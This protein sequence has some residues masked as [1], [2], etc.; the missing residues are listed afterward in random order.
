MNNKK[1]TLAI[2]FNELGTLII[3]C[4]ICVGLWL[5][6]WQFIKSDDI[7]I[8]LAVFAVAALAC[9]I[10]IDISISARMS[11]KLG[12]LSVKPV[13]AN[14]F[15]L[16]N[17][18]EIEK[19]FSAAE[20][21][22]YNSIKQVTTRAIIVL[23]ALFATSFLLGAAEIPF[24]DNEG[25]IT[26]SVL[27]M[28]CL[29]TQ[30][31]ISYLFKIIVSEAPD[32]KTELTQN[33]YPL[34]NS[35]IKES[36]EKMKITKPV[37]VF[38]TSSGIGVSEWS[39]VVYIYLN[40]I[41]TALLTKDELRSVI[42][43]EF[44]HYL[45]KDTKK[46]LLYAQFSQKI[47]GAVSAFGIKAILSSSISKAIFNLTMYEAVS[48][49]EKEIKADEYVIECGEAQNYINA[50]AKAA[51]F[52][53]YNGYEWKETSYDV[54][55]SETPV[56][57]IAH[58]DL[59]NYFKQLEIYRER[60]YFTLDNELPQRIDSHPTFA[61]RKK[62]CNVESYNAERYETDP[63]Y[64][65]EQERLLSLTDKLA[66]DNFNIEEYKAARKSIYDERNEILRQMNEAGESFAFASENEKMRCAQALMII[67]KQRALELFNEVLATSTN[68][69]AYFLKGI[70]LSDEYDDGCIEAFRNAAGNTAF[71]D[72]SMDRLAL[73]AL[74]TGKKE[75]IEEYRANIAEKKQKSLN[76]EIAAD[77]RNVKLS[78]PDKND[79][80]NVQ[81]SEAIK[82]AWGEAL[83]SVWLAENISETGIRSKYFAIK[84]KKIKNFDYAA[85]H[86]DMADSFFR[87]SDDKTNFAVF[88]NGM[89]Y[90]R[91]T[92]TPDSLIYRAEK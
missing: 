19:D 86:N 88:Y 17:K 75:I 70:I 47:E 69:L 40:A 68:S 65:A 2:L 33:A 80:I 1:H 55:Q 49:R 9:Y 78:S 60:W 71:F 74:K 14:D 11:K 36:A 20:E 27:P 39:D 85:A 63:D 13:E 76:A 35:I 4:V 5:I 77:I 22:T 58:R 82:T 48:S 90:K 81:A 62:A 6:G 28:I 92:K 66:H 72:E 44:A 57:D 89:Q 31:I 10:V 61:M 53:L 59:A 18:A 41:E 29:F 54:Y 25:G 12:D 24:T 42:L 79:M 8:A 21:K 73:Y 26:L 3:S 87:L 34:I 37:K 16:K 23:I 30:G 52:M 32:E 43:H 84:L 64:I 51:L 15:M 7:F 83:S 67:D 50:T 46:S 38:L 56:T 45:N 91:I